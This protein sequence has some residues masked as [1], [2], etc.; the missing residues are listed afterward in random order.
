[1]YGTGYNM[2][3]LYGAM[4]DCNIGIYFPLFIYLLYLS[5]RSIRS[6]IYC[7]YCQSLVY[8]YSTVQYSTVQ[9]C[10][11]LSVYVQYVQYRFCTIFQG[12][13][14]QKIGQTVLYTV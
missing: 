14:H 9:Y 13:I 2:P 4:Q 12:L 7:T 11:V 10:T 5:L 6:T 3:L 8:M 1:M